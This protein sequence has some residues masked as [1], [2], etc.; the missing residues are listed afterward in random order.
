MNKNTTDTW[1]LLFHPVNNILVIKHVADYEP[2]TELLF[3]NSG[4]LS[5][6]IKEAKKSSH[7]YRHEI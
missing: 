5:Q 2:S 3:L 6:M 1:V 4:Y 7:E